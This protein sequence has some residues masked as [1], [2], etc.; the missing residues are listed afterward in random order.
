MH[1]TK[2]KERSPGL[3]ERGGQRERRRRKKISRRRSEGERLSPLEAIMPEKKE[4]AR[5]S[6]EP[7]KESREEI[8]KLL[9]DLLPLFGRERR[10]REPLFERAS[11]ELCLSGAL[12]GDLRPGAVRG[13]DLSD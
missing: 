13:S 10:R 3:P 7:V 11:E 12:E 2:N 9:F 1:R 5:G 6:E 8:L 4:E